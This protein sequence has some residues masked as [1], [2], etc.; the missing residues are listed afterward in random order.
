MTNY[1][2]RI[3]DITDLLV[4][5]RILA[6]IGCDHAYV[7]IK[8]VKEGKAQTAFACDVHKGPLTR[9]KE[10]I[11]NAGLSSKITSVLSDGFH[12]LDA[13][14]DAASI[15][16]M[17]G[18]LIRDILSACP[19]KLGSVRQ[20]ILGPHSEVPELRKYIQEESGFDIQ[21]EKLVFEQEKF[22]VLM[23]VRKKTDPCSR[24]WSP[25]EYITGRPSLQM[26]KACY[27]TYLGSL[28]KKTQQTLDRIGCNSPSA[29]HRKEELMRELS[30]LRKT[31]EHL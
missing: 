24:S 22:Y 17:G 10:N 26:D 29:L 25:A 18:L 8:A 16:G 15:C 7:C 12:S 23:D 14:F 5:C 19:E 2:Q 11:E 6:D 21:A 30:A 20:M 4:P 1:P 31:Y 13:S 28:I 3:N 27:R 9:A